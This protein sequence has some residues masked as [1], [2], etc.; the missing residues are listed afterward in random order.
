MPCKSALAAAGRLVLAPCRWAA[1]AALTAAALGPE[2]AAKA[3]AEG[4]VQEAGP[5]E[6][7][8]ARQQ[9]QAH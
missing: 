5:E 1:L 9:R 2:T 7:R 3:R 8:G 4:Q 6:E